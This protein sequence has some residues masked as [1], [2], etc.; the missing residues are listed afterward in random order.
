MVSINNKARIYFFDHRPGKY[1]PGRQSGD[2][3]LLNVTNLMNATNVSGLIA[4]TRE[5]ATH[6]IVHLDDSD[7]D[8]ALLGIWPESANGDQIVVCLTSVNRFDP[9][10]FPH[11]VSQV[12]GFQRVT[13]FCRDT[14]PLRHAD[15]FAAF[16][17][18]LCADAKRIA[19]GDIASYDL[20][21]RR[22]LFDI[23][24]HYLSALTILCQTY[25]ILHISAAPDLARSSNQLNEALD[26]LCLWIAL[27]ESGE[28]LLTINPQQKAGSMTAQWWMETLTSGEAGKA[29]EKAWIVKARIQKEWEMSMNSGSKDKLQAEYNW[30]DVDA[31]LRAVGFAGSKAEGAPP[32]E[33]VALE[34][35]LVARAYSAI[36]SLMAASS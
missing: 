23:S 32:N 8:N 35:V 9:I 10:E 7:R 11:R 31:L 20:N 30:G 2:V 33:E 34:P 22:M 1:D 19:E 28:T 21:L 24:E 16:C 4:N 26:E 18:L 36:K 5:D 15:T 25:L 29:D 13:F 17:N 3:A 12:D 6:L 27:I 14:K